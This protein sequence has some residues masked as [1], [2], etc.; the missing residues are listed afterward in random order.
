MTALAGVH[1]IPLPL[2][3][4]QRPAGHRRL[5]YALPFEGANMITLEDCIAMGD[6]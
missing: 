4:D 1:R 6:L 2:N 3:A 5:G